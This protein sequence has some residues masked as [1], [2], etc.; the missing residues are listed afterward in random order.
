LINFERQM[1]PALIISLIAAYFLLLLVISWFSGRGAGNAS[2]FLGDRRSPWYVVAFGMIG[3][4]LSGVTFISVP[5]W[6][7]DSQFSYMQMVLG[8]LV[9]YAVIAH[10]LM[11]LYYRLQLTSIYTY[12]DQRFG[13]FSYKTG[14]SFFLLSRIIG[15]SFRLF[16]VA[17]VLQLTVFNAWGIPF[18]VTV[19]VTIA[20]IWLYTHRGGIRTIIWTDTLQTF[21]MLAAVVASILLITRAMDLSLGDMIRQVAAGE[22][23]R[24]WVFDDA[25]KENHFVKHF[26]SGAFITIVMTGLDQDMMQ[27]NL[28]CRNIRDAQ[29]NVYLMSL[30]LVP[31]NLVFLF[32]GAVLIHFAAFAAI[33]VPP[34]TDELF[35]LIATGG[36]LPQVVGVFFIVGLVAAAYSSADSALTAL[37]TSFTVDILEGDRMGEERLTRTRRFVHLGISLVL[38]AVIMLF[39]VINDQSVISA[40]FTF[41]GY[42]YGPLLGL[43][44][45]GLFTRRKVR[46]RLVPLLAVLSPVLTYLL[47]HYF[48]QL[49]DVLVRLLA[50]HFHVLSMKLIAFYQEFLAGYQFGFE[51]LIINGAIMFVALLLT[52]KKSV[53]R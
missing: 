40:L 7:V 4:S 42:T 45:F 33:P 17:T 27:K 21:A 43:Y 53:S 24:I 41:A 20:L 5:G 18:W 19:L 26:L 30:S 34:S 14:A 44:A 37:T 12:L 47:S 6:V 31:V 52:C 25:R 22:H 16:L 13:R 39:R 3:A 23:S 50:A 2:F 48:Q 15:A 49:F 8:Y 10:V 29:K 38:G 35:P 32:L 28:S 36:Y 11:P 51:L 46:D 1:S 9:G